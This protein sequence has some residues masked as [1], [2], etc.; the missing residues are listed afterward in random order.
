[1]RAKIPVQGPDINVLDGGGEPARRA[2]ASPALGLAQ[3]N[4]IGGAVAG[5]GKGLP[6]HEGFQ[7]PERLPILGLPVLADA[8]ADLAQD[9][10]RQMQYP[11]PVE[12][13]KAGVVSDLSQQAGSLGCAPANPLISRRTLPSGRTKHHATQ[14]AVQPIT[15]PILQVLAHPA[16]IAQIM[17]AM[18]G[19]V[20]LSTGL[21][22][23]GRADF[24]PPQRDQLLQRAFHW[25]GLE[26]WP[27]ADR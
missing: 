1:M 2:L 24:V 12:N 19:G 13:E 11:H 10:A 21:P 22:L 20:Q 5:A 27:V 4:P 3:E 15:H 7:Q 18:Q 26:G 25:A 23:A 17:V 6:V 14:G 16:A 8:P 9:M